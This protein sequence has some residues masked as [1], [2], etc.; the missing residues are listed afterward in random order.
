MMTSRSE[1]ASPAAG[2]CRHP[3]DPH[4]PEYGLVEDDRWAKYQHTQNI[5]EAG[6]AAC[7]TPTCALPTLQ[8][9]MTAAG[10]APA[11][12]GGIAGKNCCAARRSTTTLWPGSSAGGGDHAHAGGTAGDRDQIRRLHCPAG[13]HDPGGGPPRK[14]LIPED[15]EYADLTGLTLEARE[16]LA[17]IRPKNLGQAGRIPGVSPSDVAQLSIALAAHT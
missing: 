14:T 6:A 16:K 7:T 3:P 15:F 8:A 11:A 2:Q 10:L 4:R 12:E 13:P 1:W 5:L 9:A 17:R